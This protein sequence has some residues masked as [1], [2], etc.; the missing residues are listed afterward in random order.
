MGVAGV[1]EFGGGLLMVVG[2]LVRPAAV[3]LLLEMLVAYFIAHVP[4]GAV[5]IQNGGEL[6]LLYGAIFLFLAAHGAGPLSVDE[7]SARR[8]PHERRHVRDRRTQAAA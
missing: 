7:W 4:R 5:P 8:V 1:L 2:F 6:A 3:V